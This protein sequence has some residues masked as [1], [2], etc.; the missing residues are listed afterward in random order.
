MYRY[1]YTE[2]S[3]EIRK[4][5]LEYVEREGFVNTTPY[6]YDDIDEKGLS[7]HNITFSASTSVLFVQIISLISNPGDVVLVTG[8]NYGLF[9][10]RIERA[11]AEASS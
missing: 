3:D 11:G 6:S 10:I 1:P 8:P 4:Q 5:L 7:V 2:G 9:T